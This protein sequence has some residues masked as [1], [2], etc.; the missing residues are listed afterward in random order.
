M[1]YAINR[2]LESFDMPQVRSIVRTAAKDN[3][4]LSALVL[5]IVNSDAFRT[6]AAEAAPRVGAAPTN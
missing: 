3:Y 2:Q 1:M 5:G 6:Q 4:T